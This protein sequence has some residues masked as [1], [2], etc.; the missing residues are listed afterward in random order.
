[1]PDVSARGDANRRPVIYAGRFVDQVMGLDLPNECI[2]L[3]EQDALSYKLDRVLNQANVFILLDLLSFPLESM[4]EEHGEVPTIVVLPS[5]LDAESL[6]ATFSTLFE[7]LELFDHIV[8]SD[9]AL[10]EELRRKYRWAKSQRIPITSNEP[11]EVATVVCTLFEAEPTPATTRGDDQH[12]AA[13]YWYERNYKLAT[14]MA[15]QAVQGINNDPRFNKA[16]HRAQAAVLRPRFAAPW[17]GGDVTVP[18][19]V[20]EV[21]AGV[22]R[23]TSSFDPMKT[24]F[25][26]IDVCEDLV[27][28]AR[29][30]FPDQRFDR[31][32]PDLLFPYDDES[33]DLVFSVTIMHRNPAPAKRTLLSEMW[34]VVR[35]GGQLLFLENFVF[36]KQLD[37][38]TVHPISVTGFVDLIHETMAGQVVLEHVESLRY[39]DEYLHRGGL[40]SLLKLGVPKP[41]DFG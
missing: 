40:I 17:E 6:I 15:H 33:F 36:T 10:W 18:L 31:L 34:R 7:G 41:D 9:S 22:G 37:K 20:L 4:T 24:R 12:E 28:D 8:T 35:P 23:W 19:D 30:N 26:G 27:R 32:G 29:A 38:P 5:G 13:R 25:V 39:P 21:G 3:G 1:M 11:G 16:L 2:V 14:S